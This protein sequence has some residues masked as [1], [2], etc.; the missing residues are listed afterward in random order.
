MIEN[1]DLGDDENTNGDQAE[2]SDLSQDLLQVTSRVIILANEGSGT[3]EESVGT[4]TDHD[5]LGFSLLASRATDA[6]VKL[7]S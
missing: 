6:R 1:K 3:T 2:R 7:C 4:C 5:A